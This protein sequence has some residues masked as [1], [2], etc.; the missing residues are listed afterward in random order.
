M[1]KSMYCNSP[2]TG[3]TWEHVIGQSI[4]SP[5]HTFMATIAKRQNTYLLVS[6]NRARWAS[7]YYTHIPMRV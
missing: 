4:Q 5:Q 6:T 1:H 2:W 3:C 7:Y